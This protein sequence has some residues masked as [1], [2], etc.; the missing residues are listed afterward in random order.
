MY[1]AQQPPP[2]VASNF[3]PPPQSQQQYGAYGPV[4]PPPQAQQQMGYAI[5]PGGQSQQV[6]GFITDLTRS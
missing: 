6:L 1:G 2:R 5:G 3:P 4:P